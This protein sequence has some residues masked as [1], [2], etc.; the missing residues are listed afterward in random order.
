M[1]SSLC[2]SSLTTYKFSALSKT[3]VNTVHYT[4]PVPAHPQGQRQAAGNY[5][6]LAVLKKEINVF[7]KN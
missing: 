2:S 4:L 1:A 7:V 5:A 6:L 3:E